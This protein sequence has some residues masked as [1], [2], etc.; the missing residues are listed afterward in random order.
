MIRV[1]VE[2]AG[3]RD[4]VSDRIRSALTGEQKTP[5]RLA[6]EELTRVLEKEDWRGVERICELTS[7]E[8]NTVARRTINAFADDE[9]LDQ[10]Q[11]ERLVE[12]V[13]ELWEKT[14]ADLARPNPEPDDYAD[15]WQRRN[16]AF[17]AAYLQRTRELLTTE[18]HEKLARMASHFD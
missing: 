3:E 15:Y 1:S 12:L 5:V 16:A 9:Q 4:A 17:V 14:G 10:S 7:Y 18:Q 6:G 2:H 13:D 8:F 11:R